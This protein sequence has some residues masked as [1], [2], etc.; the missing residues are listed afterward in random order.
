MPATETGGNL[1]DL[2]DRIV[3]VTGGLGQLGRQFTRALLYAGA[4]V[5]VFDLAPAAEDFEETGRCIYL[6]ADVTDRQS[7]ER[8]EAELVGDAMHTGDLKLALLAR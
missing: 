5:A 4:R 8:A 3:V 7:L 1:F 6:T 2:R